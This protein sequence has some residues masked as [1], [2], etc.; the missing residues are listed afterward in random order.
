M[1]KKDGFSLIE[2]MIVIA[3][4]AFLAAVSMPTFSKM[5][6]K[7][8]RTEAYLNLHALYAAQKV[9][10]AEHGSYTT[11]LNGPDSA[12]WSPEGYHGGG[13]DENF[14]YTYG[15]A[16]GGEGSSYFTGKLQTSA[17]FLSGS[18]ADKTGFVAYAVGDID[19]DGKPDIL[20]INQ[21]NVITIVQD[22][23]VD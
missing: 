5:M 1:L 23:L 22:D 10:W 8:K 18:S 12:G 9:Y 16:Q 15:F 3:I 21:D 6:A 17:A 11:S 4:I 7:S 13:S 2:L 14:Y 20:S 19:G